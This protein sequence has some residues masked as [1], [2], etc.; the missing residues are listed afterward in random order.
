M[1]VNIS[2]SLNSDGEALPAVAAPEPV[3][4]LFFAVADTMA[5]FAAVTALDLHDLMLDPLLFAAA[6]DMPDF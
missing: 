1:P 5:D 6:G 4:S 2:H 3:A